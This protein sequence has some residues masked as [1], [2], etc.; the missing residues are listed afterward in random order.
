MGSFYPATF[1]RIQCVFQDQEK[2]GGLV[3]FLIA[4]LMGLLIPLT[5]SWPF[6][7]LAA[8]RLDPWLCSSSEPGIL[9]VDLAPA[10]ETH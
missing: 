1:L 2:T 6:P 3:G 8:K 9:F 5:C 7:T 10:L 4:R